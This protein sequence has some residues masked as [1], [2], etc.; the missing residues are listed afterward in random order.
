MMM[1]S[2]AARYAVRATIC[3]AQA[4]DAPLVG[5]EIAARLRAPAHYLAKILQ[6][7]TR[8]GLL[9]SYRGR[10]GGFAL[11]RSADQIAVLEVVRAIEG[12]GFGCACF[13]GL[14]ICDSVNPCA[15]HNEWVAA[16]DPLLAA[17]QD[18]TIH[19]LI[20]RGTVLPMADLTQA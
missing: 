1:L 3:L 16:R 4:D 11:A 10:G 8:H 15:L 20:A 7:M 17:L 13:L 6:D 18:S 19:D 2:Q 9:L 5:K 14:G 12:P